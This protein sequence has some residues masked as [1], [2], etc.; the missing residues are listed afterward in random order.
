M[1]WNPFR[2]IDD[3]DAIYWERD[4]DA[5]ILRR[6]RFAW[7]CQGHIATGTAIWHVLAA[8]RERMF[9]D[10]GETLARYERVFYGVKSILC[11]LV[12]RT[13]LPGDPG[14]KRRLESFPVVW[15]DLEEYGTPDGPGGSCEEVHVGYGV[16]ENWFAFIERESWP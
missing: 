8:P 15:F 13:G 2:I 12:G 4:E 14:Y 10:H 1:S 6:T 16:F 5:P 9:S 3:W 7:W 11:L